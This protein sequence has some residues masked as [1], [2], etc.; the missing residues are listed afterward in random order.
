MDAIVNYETDFNYDD[1]YF[2]SPSSINGG[3]YFIK[4]VNETTPLYIQPPKCILKN[5]IM[6]S[7]KRLYCDLMFT[8]SDEKFIEWIENLENICHTRI[9]ENRTKW[10]ESNLEKDDIEN[11]FSSPF[12]IYK[13]GSY[14]ILRTNI[15]TILGKP[16]IK[17]YD[18]NGSE[19]HIDDI[20]TNEHVATILEIQGIRC[21]AR[22]FQLEFVIKQMLTIKHVDIFDTFLLV[23]KKDTDGTYDEK[24]QVNEAQVNEAQVNEAQVNEAQVN[25]AQVN[26]AQV[27]ASQVDATQVDAS[28]VDASQVDAS[29]VDEAQI[30]KSPVDDDSVDASQ[31]DASQIDKSPVDDDSVDDDSVDVSRVDKSQVDDDSV[32]DLVKNNENKNKKTTDNETEEPSFN[33]VTNTEKENNT[34]EDIVNFREINNDKNNLVEI[35]IKPTDEDT[36]FLKERNDIYYNMYREAL[37]KAKMAKSLALT[38][39]LE[40]KR[41]K[42]TYM[43]TDLSDDSDI[44]DS[45]HSEDD[46]D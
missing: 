31:V 10:F 43:L 42:N 19:I 5:G 46:S 26:E 44:D 4:I 18:E 23:N 20:K 6:K 9:Y 40:A 29:Q 14:Y 41:I 2:T 7:G 34:K 17:I 24:I 8:K 16:N 37:Q 45:I 15:P 1:L 33:I 25:E 28:Q 38:N 22:S 30:D 35:D 36:V 32:D 12:K 39:Y 13:S 27:D 3:N 21:S 11:S